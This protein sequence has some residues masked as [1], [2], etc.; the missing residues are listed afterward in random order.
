MS[1]FAIAVYDEDVGFRPPRR[2]AI[3]ADTDA[4]AY[5]IAKKKFPDAPRIELKEMP[6]VDESRYKN[7]YQDV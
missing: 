5:E 2:G 1:I 6:G 4:Q 3:K 7:G